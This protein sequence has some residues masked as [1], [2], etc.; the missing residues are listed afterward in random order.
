M[1]TGMMILAAIGVVIVVIAIVVSAFLIGA[2]LVSP[3]AGLLVGAL[4]LV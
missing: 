4:A 1:G 3:F 2:A